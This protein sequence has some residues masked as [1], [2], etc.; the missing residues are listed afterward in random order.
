MACV[1]DRVKPF[2]CLPRS[3]EIDVAVNEFSDVFS[4]CKSA[5]GALIPLELPAV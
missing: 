5:E 1:V 2:L 4:H 3:S